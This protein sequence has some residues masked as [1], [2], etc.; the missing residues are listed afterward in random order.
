MYGWLRP[1]YGRLQPGYEKVP[2]D[3]RT[4]RP[5]LAGVLKESGIGDPKA[6]Y[7]EYLRK[8]YS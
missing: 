8:K 6:E 1:A 4:V 3:E 5:E 7:T 2:P